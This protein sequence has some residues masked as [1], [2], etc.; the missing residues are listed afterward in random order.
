MKYIIVG[1]SGGLGLAIAN[2][3]LKLNNEVIIYDIKEPEI[4]L[5]NAVYK[6][7]NLAEDDINIMQNDLDNANGLI[8]TA[9]IGRVDYFNNYSF[10]DIELTITINLT[11]LIKILSLSSKKLLSNERFDCLCISSIAG[12]VASP[13]FSIYSASKAGVCKYIEAVNTEIGKLGYDNRI[14]NVV[15]TSFNGTGFNGG[16]TDI[17]QLSDLADYIIDSMKNRIELCKVNEKLIDSIINRYY[18]NPKKY[19]LESFEYKIR[20][21]RIK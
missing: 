10:K 21:K 4:E 9:G 13:L 1:G 6:R 2:K 15:A 18:D 7:I 11:S 14:T 8:Y 17:N 3:L 16:E 12:L 5:N 19:A 20:N